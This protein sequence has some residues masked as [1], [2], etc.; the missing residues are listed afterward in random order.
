MKNAELRG[1]HI[2]LGPE[3]GVYLMTQ[4]PIGELTI[5]RLDEL[6]GATLTY[7]DEI[8]PTVMTMAFPGLYRRR[9]KN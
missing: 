1:I 2:A 4:I 6:V 9:K 7:V 3:D 8:F 5:E